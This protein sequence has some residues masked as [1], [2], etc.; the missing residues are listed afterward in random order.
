LWIGLVK[1]SE[2]F[3][4]ILGKYSEN[5]RK[6]LGK[7]WLVN[8]SE[9]FPRILRGFSEDFPRFSEDFPRIFRVLLSSFFV[10]QANIAPEIS[11]LSFAKFWKSGVG[12]YSDYF[13]REIISHARLF[14]SLVA[15]SARD[16]RRPISVKWTFGVFLGEFLSL[17]M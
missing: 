3:R 14:L 4:K 7:Y 12:V 10:G 17:V 9:D 11:L 13:T 15:F 1:S 8:F 5:T 2:N 6:I 16:L